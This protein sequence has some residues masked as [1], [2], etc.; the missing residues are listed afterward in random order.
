MGEYRSVST[1]QHKLRLE[2]KILLLLI[3]FFEE[4]ECR[5]AMWAVPRTFKCGQIT[6][7]LLHSFVVK[8]ASHHYAWATS[9]WGQHWVHFLRAQKLFMHKRVFFRLLGP[10]SDANSETRCGCIFLAVVEMLVNNLNE[11][12][13]I[14]NF[15]YCVFAVG[16]TFD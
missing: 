15:K 12:H 11:L 4:S 1:W 13:E 5:P 7:D 10:V 6:D 2:S 9:P 16:Q 3:K 8:V 14:F